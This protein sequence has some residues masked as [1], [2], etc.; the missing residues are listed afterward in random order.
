[1]TRRLAPLA[2]TLAGVAALALGCAAPGPAPSTRLPET[3]AALARP[4]PD[5][6]CKGTV[7]ERLLAHGLEQVTVAVDVDVSGRAKV[8]RFLSPELTPAAEAEVRRAFE[9]CPW[10]PGAAGGT[11]AATTAVVE[12]RR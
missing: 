12:V 2:A 8:V 5:P 1:M 4:E 11:P 10:T 6:S 9:E 7:R 3:Q